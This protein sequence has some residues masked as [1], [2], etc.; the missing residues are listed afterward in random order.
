MKPV[1]RRN[2]RKYTRRKKVE[3]EDKDN[4]FGRKPVTSRSG[5]TRGRRRRMRRKRRRK[6]RRRRRK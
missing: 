5:R 6:R 2:C 1:T 3:E 4:E